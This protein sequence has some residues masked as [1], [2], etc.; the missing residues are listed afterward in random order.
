M[1][2][3]QKPVVEPVLSAALDPAD[4]LA[5]R[6]RVLT[7]ANVI[8]LIGCAVLVLAAVFWTLTARAPDTIIGKGMI[9]PATGFAEAGIAADGVVESV[10]VSPGDTVSK[11]EVLATVQTAAGAESVKAPITGEVVYLFARP[12]RPT[13]L[14]QPLVILQPDTTNV[15]RALMPADQ[16]ETISPGMRAWVSPSSAP[17]G[18][19]GFIVGTVKTVSP[20]PVTRE[21][22]LATLG[23]NA[24]LVDYLL[25]AGPSQEVTIELNEGDTPSGYEWT[26]GQGPDYEINSSTLS[27]VAVVKDNPTVFSW[28]VS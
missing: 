24:A 22:L 15:A 2:V 6:S 20:A 16:A 10:S 13:Q 14:G 5:S 8:G 27:D 11:G 21:Q 3:P 19:Y 23:D 7:R 12:G 28:L 1:P 4:E 17:R 26:I 18:Q 25:S 9:V